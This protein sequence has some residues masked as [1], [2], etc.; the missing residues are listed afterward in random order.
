MTRLRA[1][2]IALVTFGA[3]ILFAAAPAQAATPNS[4][5]SFDITIGGLPLS[6]EGVVTSDGASCGPSLQQLG[7]VVD[8][9]NQVSPG[10]G[11][12]LLNA[13]LTSNACGTN[14]TPAP[15]LQLSI[16]CPN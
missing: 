10:F 9:L 5:C 6:I 13:I 4:D 3:V 12:A 8:L 14:V 16:D 7:T 15:A 11:D 2:L 1:A